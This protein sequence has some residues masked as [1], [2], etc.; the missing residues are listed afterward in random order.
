MCEFPA[1]PWPQVKEV[2]AAAA[3]WADDFA[4]ERQQGQGQGPSVWGEEFASFQA[5][6]HPGAA[7]GDQW[8]QDFA[9]AGTADSD[10]DARGSS[11]ALEGSFM[12]QP[13]MQQQL[14]ALVS[15]ALFAR[16]MREPSVQR[17]DPDRPCLLPCRCGRRLGR[18]VCR[19]RAW[20]WRVG[21]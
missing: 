15:T 11:Q 10:G 19:R 18:P 17:L 7:T 13:A 5:K 2:P 14:S 4:A 1:P 20:R 6:Q 9:G 12:A 8:A 21:S 3:A 16:R